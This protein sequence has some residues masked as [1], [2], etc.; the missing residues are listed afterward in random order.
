MNRRLL[1]ATLT[2]SISACA[3]G[4]ASENPS[5]QVL[6]GTWDVDLR[7]KP[8]GP[9]YMKTLVVTS[10][11]GNRFQ[12]SF[13]DTEITE[14]RIN[15]E[16][17]TVRIAFITSDGSGPYNHSAVLSSG[18]LEGLTNSTGRNFLAYWSAS[19]K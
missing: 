3:T 9:A 14:G 10:V 15:V 13:Y 19:K 18:K 6:L 1:L 12:G 16:W 4:M 17:G 8:D 7:P 11:S 5:G 2:L